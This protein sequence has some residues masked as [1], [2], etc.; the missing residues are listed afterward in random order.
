MKLTSFIVQSGK[1]RSQIIREVGCSQSYFS[2]ME[3]DQRDVGLGVLP[4]LA[5]AL[6][7]S[8][9]ILRPDLARFTPAILPDAELRPDV[10]A[11]RLKAVC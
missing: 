1:S 4:D 7:I 8:P 6:G 2:L 11:K 5:R 3:N 10:D 9:I